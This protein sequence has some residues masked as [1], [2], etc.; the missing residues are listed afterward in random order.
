MINFSEM[1][2]LF[3]AAFIAAQTPANSGN[4]LPTLFQASTTLSAADIMQKAQAA[5]GG[6]T[7]V[8]P[9][10]L[11][12]SGYAVFYKNGVPV[13]HEVHNMWRVYD[14][15]KSD[16]HRADGK[17]R[18]ES[19][20]D[21]KPVINIS[22]DGTTTYTANGPQPASA[23]DTQW[24]SAFGFGVGRHAFD[25]GY[26]LERLADDL[27]DGHPVYTVKITTPAGSSTH[28]WLA[29]N[30]YAILK[31]GFDTPRGW[32]ER[33]Y[34]NFFKNAETDWQQPG[35][36]RLYYDGVKSN[37]VIWLSFEINKDHPDCLFTLPE[38]EDCRTNN[39]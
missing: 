10:S 34:S 12:M 22:F 31:I 28:F 6:E 20:R 25:P 14:R 1:L 3:G 30:N 29:Q 33:I 16:A 7:W 5:A 32:H 11:A 17:V 2:S 38:T 21:G 19:L 4:G 27:V 39:R 26:S 9:K 37:E 18:I 23:A 35:R 15:V 8:N 36:V 13:K 24:A